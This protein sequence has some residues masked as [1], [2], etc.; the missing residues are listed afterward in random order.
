MGRVKT[1]ARRSFLVGTA[2]LFGGVAFGTYTVRTPHPNPLLDGLEDGEAS[3][4]PW[5]KITADG[6]T[7]QT[8]HVEIGQGA[9]QVQSILIAEEMDLEPGQFSFAY[10][11]PDPAYYNTAFAT[12][13]SEVM[14]HM[15]PF[16]AAFLEGAV[17]AVVKVAGFQLTGGSTTVPDSFDKLRVAGAV[18]RET[19]KR[20][21]SV[22]T[23]LPEEKLETRGGA[24]ILP[25]GRSLSYTSLAQTASE[26][27]PVE[28]VTLRP[29]SQWRL[30]GK[31]Q[32]RIDIV[33]KSTGTQAFGIDVAHQGM[34]YAA[35][36]ANPRRGTLESY[37]AN[38]AMAMRGVQAVVEVENGVAAIA[39]NTWR[40]MQAVEAID[41]TFGPA[42]Y[43]AEQKDHW[44]EVARSFD[45]DARFDAEWRNDG[46]VDM[47]EGEEISVEYRAPYVAH[48]PLEPLNATALVTDETVDVWTGT[49][50]AANMIASIA[51]IT[52]HDPSTIRIHNQ[53]SGGSFGHR[54]EFPPIKHVI[55]LA[56]QMRGTPVKLTYSREEDFAQD[57]TRQIAMA[58][59]RAK[60]SQGRVVAIDLDCA[61]SPLMASGEDGGGGRGPDSQVT[62][63]IFNAPYGIEN[64]RNRGWV[65]PGLAPVSYW[66]SVGASYG[67]FFIETL[68]DEAIQKAGADPMA[69]RLRLV[70]D[71]T[72]RGVLERVAEISD[73]QGSDIGT[74]RGRGLALV[75]SFGVPVA[76]V[77]DVTA[78]SQGI[79][80]DDVWVVADP[81]TVIDPVNLEN[82]I[83]G[84]VIWGL[85]HAMNSE[86]TYADGMAEQTNYH[87]AE[88][89][90]LHQTPRIHVTVLENNPR[91]RGMGEPSVPPAAPALANA[92][93]AATGLRLREMPFFKF[94]DFV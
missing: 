83:Q 76:Q 60:V 38:R 5:I 49:Q 52:G 59:G 37:D 87:A 44:A 64:F 8:P 62:A 48:Q 9:A 69:E 7:F 2:A 4:N 61:A 63:G 26:I 75:S 84:G 16:P 15:T 6:I 30:I 80:I 39:D 13:I 40:A 3:F 22:E 18:A 91:I 24:V 57:A 88:G 11:Q 32:Q 78:T 67:G 29:P 65:V 28:G 31:P 58:R 46:D 68:M 33:P 70:N 1:I 55:T 20:A 73:W 94:V 72:A 54:L 50:V 17:G 43:P 10:P 23:G 85:G 25:D 53:T 42:T 82:Q 41:C 47:A 36:R 56:N 92:I 74:G 90:R 51:D 93:F 19:L 45:M 66:R 81:G 27:S 79:R 21:A 71:P 12:E 86:I 35:V 14:Q 77:V 34:V 89:M